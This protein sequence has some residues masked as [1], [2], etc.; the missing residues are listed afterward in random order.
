[1]ETNNKPIKQH[2]FNEIAGEFDTHVRQSI[3]LFGE[4][5]EQLAYAITKTH[6]DGTILD[7]C[8]STGELGRMLRTYG[9]R[10]KYVNVDGSPK[11]IAEMNKIN[12][13]YSEGMVGILGG[14]YAGWT[15]ESGIE[16]PEYT[17]DDL[18]AQF[19][20]FDVIVESLGFQF[21]TTE[22]HMYVEKAM[23]HGKD[24]VFIEK[25]KSNNAQEWKINEH[26]KDKMHKSKYFTEEQIE[27][28]KT[29]VLTD[30]GDYLAYYDE[31]EGILEE[32]RTTTG[33]RAYMFYHAGN[34]R[35]YTTIPP[36]HFTQDLIIN[37]FNA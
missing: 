14:Y 5:T 37:K 17:I 19:G 21:F 23:K 16:I 6:R 34:F 29:E 27:S 7:V 1:M 2:F 35:G 15:D 13:N 4:A 8:G 24:V 26:I 25:F 22:R 3:P 32:F 9:F 30:M 18:C 28:K 11:M 20:D 10:G 12:T 33:A 31:F 36:R